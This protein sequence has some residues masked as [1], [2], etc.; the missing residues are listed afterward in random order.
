[1][2]WPRVPPGALCGADLWLQPWSAGA[3]EQPALVL[4]DLRQLVDSTGRARVMCLDLQA[5]P[6]EVRSWWLLYEFPGASTGMNVIKALAR[7]R[8]RA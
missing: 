5:F 4:D 3:E 7:W 8:W 6:A 1:M 2:Y